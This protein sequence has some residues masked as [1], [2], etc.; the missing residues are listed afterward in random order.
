M[1]DF[2]FYYGTTDNIFINVTEIVKD[3][4]MKDGVITIENLSYNS[5]FTDPSPGIVKALKIISTVDKNRKPIYISENSSF[6]MNAIH[7]TFD[8]KINIVYFINIYIADKYHFMMNSQLSDLKKSG[9]LDLPDTNIYVIASGPNNKKETF[10]N[11]VKAI[12]STANIEYSEGN[13]HEYPGIKKVWDIGQ[14]SCDGIILYFHSKG[15]THIKN[16]NE[17]NC[18]RFDELKIF[19][20]VITHWR[21][22]LW[23]FNQFN[24]IDKLGMS[25]GGIGWIWFNFWWARNSYINKCEKPH[26]STNRY[27]YEDWLSRYLNE[28]DHPLADLIES[29]ARSHCPNVEFQHK[30]PSDHQQSHI[31]MTR[32]LAS[33]KVKNND[34]F[35]ITFNDMVSIYNI[36]TKF[37]AE[38]ATFYS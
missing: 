32:G 15:I 34:C 28:Q 18:R 11:K 17:D 33:Y 25:E 31:S 24:S 21:E 20:N 26:I 30:M 14:D 36:G 5:V 27:Y 22:N 35:S 16:P 1:C 29:E 7:K 37:S 2:I 13:L 8:Q 9:L 23:I 10:I 38:M 4:F 19:N 6:S 12:I 3:K